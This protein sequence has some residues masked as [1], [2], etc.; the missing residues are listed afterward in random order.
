MKSLALALL[1]A[2]ALAAAQDSKL[3]SLPPALYVRSAVGPG[4]YSPRQLAK[5]MDYTGK[6]LSG[7]VFFLDPYKKDQA[8]ASG[9]DADWAKKTLIEE[10][11]A[12]D[13]LIEAG[14][15]LLAKGIARKEK[16]FGALYFASY[17]TLL[18]KNPTV[19]QLQRDLAI[20]QANVLGHMSSLIESRATDYKDYAEHEAKIEQWL[21]SARKSLAEARRRLEAKAN[22]PY[23][24]KK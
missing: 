18:R 23:G 17:A 24:D 11:A 2:P 10:S 1:L 20:N 6:N 7:L 4:G 3:P 16:G 15:Q 9:K 19:E 21:E 22:E 12:A 14:D 8:P 5:D 13:K